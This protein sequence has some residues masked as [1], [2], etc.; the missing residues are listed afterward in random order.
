MLTCPAILSIEVNPLHRQMG[1]CLQPCFK[2]LPDTFHS[3]FVFSY[4]T[5][6]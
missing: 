6:T 1:G 5:L 3:L 2:G 4:V